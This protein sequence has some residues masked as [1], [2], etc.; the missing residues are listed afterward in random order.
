MDDWGS[1]AIPSYDL[2]TSWSTSRLCNAKT[3]NCVSNL[4]VLLHRIKQTEQVAK[5]N[6]RVAELL[7][8]AQRRYRKPAVEKPPAAPPEVSSEAKQTL[9]DR[10]KC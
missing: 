4:C 1:T 8:V 5:F 6:E 2:L 7:A 10:P 9:D 3:P